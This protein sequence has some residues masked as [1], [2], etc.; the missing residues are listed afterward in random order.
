MVESN[1]VEET[2]EK[3]GVMAQFV[4]VE[5]APR[6]VLDKIITKTDIVIVGKIGALY[7]YM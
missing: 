3:H 7:Y 2:M 6:R 4:D 1:T 5:S